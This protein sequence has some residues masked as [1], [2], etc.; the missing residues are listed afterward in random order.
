MRFDKIEVINMRLVGNETRSI[1]IDEKKNILILLGDN[2]FGKT[3][4]L[5]AMATAMAP[6]AAQF[7]GIP[8]FQLS[9]FDV[10]L[11]RHGHRAKYLTVSA[12]FKDGDADLSSLRYRKGTTNTPKANYE[13]LKLLANA[14]KDAIIAGE[15][16]V[17]LP[18]FAYYGTGRGKFHVPER[19]RGF[20]QAF[21]R[22]DCYKSAI[23]PD[24]DFKRFFEWYDLME[25]E[26][27]RE[28]EQRRDFDY[29][30][31]ILECVRKALSDTIESFQNPKIKTRPLRFVMERVEA[32]GSRH[33][34]RIEQL[35][36]GYKIV[37]ATVADLAARMAEANPWM[38]NPLDAKGI[39]L[40]D[41]VDLHLHPKWQRT[42]LQ[43]LH[44]VF[45]NVQF[46]VS[47]HSPIIVVGAAD[48][49]QVVNL[50]TIPN[51]ADEVASVASVSNVGQVLLSDLFGLKSLQSPEWDE[52]IQERD[53]ILA[54]PELTQKDETRLAQLD[55]EMK[56]LTSLQDSNAIRSSKLL[57]KIAHQ[58]NIEL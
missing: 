52:K 30:S 55:E 12:R 22:W 56:G 46:I 31:P 41:E 29:K 35:S 37:I 23:C 45:K 8:D 33:E 38:N 1:N 15:Q 20:Q 39:V 19:K 17:E 54:K 51:N 21:E 18:V 53:D 14:K 36:E 11:N 25:D 40:I 47:T 42:I 34:L 26:E 27:R 57:E 7:P 24:T 5:D 43:D 2:G 49:A 32:D 9:D 58:L 48:I 10:H 6:F 50:N 4:M 28:R 44:R 13:E 3:T 16:N